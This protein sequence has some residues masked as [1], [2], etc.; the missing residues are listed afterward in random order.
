VSLVPLIYVKNYIHSIDYAELSESKFDDL[1]KEAI[2]VLYKSTRE[3]TRGFVRKKTLLR[4]IYKTRVRLSI[5]KGGDPLPLLSRRYQ[6]KLEHE[7]SRLV[8][9]NKVY[10]AIYPSLCSEQKSKKSIMFGQA[11][12]LATE[13]Q[14]SGYYVFTHGQS[15]TW[16]A[17][18]DVL[19]GI[20]REREPKQAD[21]YRRKWRRNNAAIKWTNV[22]E[23][24]QFQK[25]FHLDNNYNH[26]ILSVDAIFSR[27]EVAESA[28]LSFWMGRS[29]ME[30]PFTVS[31]I[32]YLECK[33]KEFTD[34]LHDFYEWVSN[35]KLGRLN[36]IAIPK[37][38]LKDEYTCFV[39]RSH[40]YGMQCTCYPTGH[41][42]FIKE[43]ERH[44]QNIVTGCCSQYRIL[45]HPL[46]LHSGIRTFTFD[47]LEPQEKLIYEQR[48]KNI[49]NKALA[50][51]LK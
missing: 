29:I 16:G 19:T 9:S 25:H 14:H 26:S 4:R 37:S 46:D 33:D 6:S 15:L 20:W 3:S 8:K 11:M 24:A 27:N 44:Q 5:V 21:Q 36:V 32:T 31:S 18:S 51:N 47:T 42:A 41:E 23:H 38:L 49:V 28:F 13:L 7:T 43:L 2:E 40:R 45:T 1:E 35:L 12:E 34:A 48:L 30:F 50:L 39:Y 17:F 10:A 22:K